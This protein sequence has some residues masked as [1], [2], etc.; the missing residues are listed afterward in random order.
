MD[1][2]RRRLAARRVLAARDHAAAEADR[3]SRQVRIPP[4]PLATAY[5][6]RRSAAAIVSGLVS[7]VIL[8]AAWRAAG[9]DELT[10]ALEVFSASL[11]GLYLLGVS[12]LAY[13]A[14]ERQRELVRLTDV[15]LY[16][17][18]IAVRLGLSF[19]HSGEDR[20]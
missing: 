3:R 4:G 18:A 19:K 2:E 14:R 15:E 7:L 1:A 16:V 12:A 8:A 5:R 9:D 10:E 17:S 13:W 11:V 6:H 20:T